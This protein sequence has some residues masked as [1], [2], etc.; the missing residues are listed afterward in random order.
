MSSVGPGA[1]TMTSS[2]YFP[3]PSWVIP[4]WT[5]TPRRGTSENLIVLFG[6]AKIASGKFFQT[7]E[8][9]TSKGP[10]I[11]CRGYGTRPDSRASDR[12]R[13]GPHASFC[14]IEHLEQEKKRN[15]RRR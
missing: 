3:I 6:S 15:Y 1:F 2:R 7:L 8:W 5:L 9:F 14:R 13:I 4:R 12:E 10:R 11:L